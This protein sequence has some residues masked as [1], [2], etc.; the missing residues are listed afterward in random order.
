MFWFTR[1]VWQRAVSS[2]QLLNRHRQVY[3]HSCL[4][5]KEGRSIPFESQPVLEL[6]VFDMLICICVYICVYI[7]IYMYREREM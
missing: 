5:P 4:L 7:Y 2:R 6:R 1:A 3:S